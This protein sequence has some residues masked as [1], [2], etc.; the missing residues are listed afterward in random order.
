MQP[1]TNNANTKLPSRCGPPWPA[2]GACE[3]RSG[4]EIIPV[5]NT[6]FWELVSKG[7]VEL[8][9]IDGIPFAVTASLLRLIDESP[10][11]KAAAWQCGTQSS[12][13]GRGVISARKG[14]AMS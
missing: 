8:A 7:L 5:G 6:K 13:S 11:S 10:R 3:G 12:Q 9:Y 4:A 1:K 2:A 14:T